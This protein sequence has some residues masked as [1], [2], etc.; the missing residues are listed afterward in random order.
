MTDTSGKELTDRS[1][2]TYVSDASE[3]EP[4]EKFPLDLL[5]RA[6][7]K[8]AAF[9]SV[10]FAGSRRT[11]AKWALLSS[12]LTDDADQMSMVTRLIG[13]TWRLT[14]LSVIVSVAG[15]GAADVE[16]DDKQQR[17]VRRG[18]LHVV[19]TTGALIVT[20]GLSGGVASLV[21]RAMHE[22]GDATLPCLGVARWQDVR[23]RRQLEAKGT[24]TRKGMVCRYGDCMKGD[25]SSRG[26]PRT[27]KPRKGKLDKED[28]RSGDG[29]GGDGGAG[30]LLLEPHHSHFI[31]VEDDEGG[32]GGAAPPSTSGHDTSEMDDEE[33]RSHAHIRFQSAMIDAIC[34]EMEGATPWDEATVASSTRYTGGVGGAAGAGGGTGGGGWCGLGTNRSK[35]GS[36]GRRRGSVGHCVPSVGIAAGAKSGACRSRKPSTMSDLRQLSLQPQN[37]VAAVQLVVGGGMS[38]LHAVAAFLRKRRPVVVLL[39]SGGAAADIYR[40]C[41][42][43]GKLPMAAPEPGSALSLKHAAAVAVAFGVDPNEKAPPCSAEYAALAARLLPEIKRMGEEPTGANRTGQLS[44]FSTADDMDKSLDMVIL[45]AILS[46][47]EKT[48]DAIM[49]AVQWGEPAIIQN[50]LDASKTHDPVGLARAFEE[51]LRLR[52]AEVIKV[53]IAFNADP[54]RVRLNRLFDSRFDVFG[55]FDGALR[56]ASRGWRDNLLGVISPAHSTP[57]STPGVSRETTKDRTSKRHMALAPSST[58]GVSASPTACGSSGGG[59]GCKDGKGGH[60]DEAEQRRSSGGLI[61]AAVEGLKRGLKRKVGFG[62]GGGG[63]D[64]GVAKRVLSFRES[65]SGFDVLRSLEIVDYDHYLR[66]RLQMGDG[67]G[68]TPTWMDLMMWAVL[69]GEIELARHLWC[70]ASQPLRAAIIASRVSRQIAARLSNMSANS[71]EY[72]KKLEENAKAYEGW[73]T[74]LLSTI[75]DTADAHQILTMVPPA[76]KHQTTRP[77]GASGD[78]GCGAAG[79]GAA[80][81]AVAGG[82]AAGALHEQSSDGAAGGGRHITVMWRGSCIDEAIKSPHHCMGVVAHPH[83]QKLLDGYFA[84][85]YAGAAACISPDS[86]LLRIAIQILPPVLLFYPQLTNAQVPPPRE[87]SSAGGAHGGGGAGGGAGGAGGGAQDDSEDAWYRDLKAIFTGLIPNDDDD[88]D[89]DDDNGD[90]GDDD[91]DG[92]GSS[93]RRRLDGDGSG[94]DEQ[95]ERDTDYLKAPPQRRPEPYRTVNGVHELLTR[96]GRA[97]ARDLASR[98]DRSELFGYP[99]LMLRPTCLLTVPKVKFLMHTSSHLAYTLLLTYVTVG[100]GLIVEPE[101]LPPWMHRAGRME[102]PE[103]GEIL[104]WLWTFTKLAEE[105]KQMIIQGYSYFHSLWNWVDLGTYCMV[106][107]AMIL[108]GALEQA[109]TNKLTDKAMAWAPDAGDAMTDLAQALYALVLISLYLRF[110]DQLTYSN[111]LGVLTLILKQIIQ[112]DLTQWLALTLFSTTA[113]SVAFVVLLPAANFE[114]VTN[115]RPSS[116]PFWSLLGDFD[117]EHMYQWLTKGSPAEYMVPALLFVYTFFSTILLVNLLIAQMS[118][119]YEEVRDDSELFWQFERVGLIRE[120]KD[121]RDPLPPPLNALY[122]VFHDLPKWL[123]RTHMRAVVWAC[124]SCCDVDLET[125][126]DPL[127]RG[128]ATPMRYSAASELMYAEQSYQR[129]YLDRTESEQRASIDRR[130]ADV[131]SLQYTL[132]AETRA[133]FEALNARLDRELGPLRELIKELRD[134]RSTLS[135]STGGG[136]QGGG[137]RQG[138]GQGSGQGDSSSGGIRTS[139]G[140]VRARTTNA[141]VHFAD[142][143]TTSAARAPATAAISDKEE[144]GLPQPRILPCTS[145]SK[146]APA[147]AASA[148]T[149]ALAPGAAA[150]ASALRTCSDGASTAVKPSQVKAR[151]RFRDRAANSPAAAASKATVNAARAQGSQRLQKLLKETPDL[152]A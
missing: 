121:N 69:I 43:D 1:V 138:G 48:T 135:S 12:R 147:P 20:D 142:A 95:G 139:G 108:R 103:G 110:M 98:R 18:L 97:K 60:V 28:S 65:S 63:G 130:V 126:D 85:D 26:N 87:P 13:E 81:G 70:K 131:A 112:K 101:N 114:E 32:D 125:Q 78:G 15:Q 67:R 42:V 39:D 122:I 128:F 31:L 148:A 143:A 137:G 72:E 146:D 92:G 88:D 102:P 35:Q 116:I 40:Y 144:G 7:D 120:Y 91:D 94:D 77:R 129:S 117:L 150:L 5:K 145:G 73:A 136:G 106:V 61:D 14:G 30:S 10:R 89:D 104:F 11:P 19:K 109:F 105:V 27:N 134:S 9:G 96:K 62:G 66:A 86:G 71:L 21:G 140:P 58:G 51:A 149:A 119:T 17:V 80:G 36:Q 115:H 29:H 59:P 57:G 133:Q 82:G 38:A 107:A 54:S 64:G 123:R 33:R 6:G 45:E 84:G 93:R 76:H 16:L 141:A 50:Q 75:V 22:S 132:E 100:F 41:K 55:V 37:R 4:E 8:E 118:S 47:C 25:V 124:G 74:G 113:F 52:N 53:L 127:E 46:D 49:L 111:S 2:G 152:D 23:F 34:G 56:V 99:L 44:F 79:V 83:C 24:G 151:A 90:G 3:D 68:L